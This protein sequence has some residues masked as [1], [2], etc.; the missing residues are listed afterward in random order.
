MKAARSVCGFSSKI[1][2]E[3]QSAQEGREA[4]GAGADIV[5]L[6]NFQPQVDMIFLISICLV[7]TVSSTDLCMKYYTSPPPFVSPTL[8]GAPCCGSCTKGGVPESADR[9]EW[10]S[11]SRKPIHVFLPTC[12]HHFPGLYNTGLPSC[13]LFS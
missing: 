7:F 2:V 3:C 4:A 1:E 13:G 12:G 5:M 11:D 10:R 6:D 9:S 8:I